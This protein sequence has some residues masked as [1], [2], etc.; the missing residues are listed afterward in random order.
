MSTVVMHNVV[1]VD[2]YIADDNDDVGPLFEWYFNGDTDA[3]AEGRR[4]KV[5]QAS[6]DYVRPTWDE[7]RVDGDRAPPVRH[8]QRLGGHAAGRRARGR[9][10]APAQAGRVAPGGVV[11]LRR[12]RGRGDREGEGA[13]RASAPLRWRRATSAGRRSPSAWWTRWRWTSCRWCSARASGTSGRSTA[14]TCWRTPTWSSGATG[15]C[16]CATGSAAE[17]STQQ[18]EAPV[19]R[20]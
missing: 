9:G 15:C 7:H 8:D 14:S 3:R 18:A 19:R 2:G 11:P 20:V 6:A 5:S 12:R 4:M 17:R 13:R 1:S 16:T 10:V